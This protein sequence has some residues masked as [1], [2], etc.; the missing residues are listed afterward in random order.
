MECNTAAWCLTIVLTSNTNNWLS[1]LYSLIFF[2][3]LSF[4]AYN[5]VSIL[6]GLKQQSFIRDS[7]IGDLDRANL[8]IDSHFLEEFQDGLTQVSI[9]YSWLSAGVSLFPFT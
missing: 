4:T 9:D 2:N 7:R 6:C 5:I 8:C 3:P 1:T